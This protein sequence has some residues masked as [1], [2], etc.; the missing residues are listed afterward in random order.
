MNK[1]TLTIDGKVIEMPPIK[2]RVWREVM[3]FEDDR[4]ELKLRSVDAVE[5]HCEVIAKVFDVTTDEVL[6]NLELQDVLPTYFAILNYV[7]VMLTEKL[8]N[9]KKNVDAAET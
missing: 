6:D 1:P 8:P 7:A 9:N 5:K 2:A 3:K 4:Q